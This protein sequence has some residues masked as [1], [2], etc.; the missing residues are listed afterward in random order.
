MIW[1][2]LCEFEEKRM[3]R[4]DKKAEEIDHKSVFVGDSR[5]RVWTWTI[6]EGNTGGRADHWFQDP[7]RNSCAQCHQKFSLTERRHHCRNCGQIFC[8]RC[9]RY[10]SDIRHLKITKPVRVCQNCYIRLKVLEAGNGP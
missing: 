3:K 6:G 7:S 5:G 4:N 1:Q 8:S 2:F 9:S 10:E